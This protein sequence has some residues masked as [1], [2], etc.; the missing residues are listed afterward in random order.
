MKRWWLPVMA[1][2]LMAATACGGQAPDAA[3]DAVPSAALSSAP[4]VSS[5]S[6]TSKAPVSRP[7]D[8]SSS[9]VADEKPTDLREAFAALEAGRTAAGKL[10]SYRYD[11]SSSYAVLVEGSAV[12]L[13]SS[14]TEAAGD[15]ANFACCRT[16]VAK[17]LHNQQL[18][19]SVEASYADRAAGHTLTYR[20]YTDYQDAG[21]NDKSRREEDYEKL[22]LSGVLSDDLLFARSD[23]ASVSRSGEESF[24]FTLRA[25]A[26]AEIVRR[27][28][29]QIAPEEDAGSVSV[30]YF[31]VTARLTDGVLTQ[32][33][34][35]VIGKTGTENFQLNSRFT[36]SGLSAGETVSAPDWA[37]S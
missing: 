14:K 11:A 16:G 31:V 17:D 24:T 10:T 26:G 21:N 25:E 36:V 35:S 30:S 29:A 37:K 3:A 12:T 28:F 34:A 33:Q 22:P 6:A 13:D 19:A 23:V 5:A 7:A 32:Y 20:S 8:V 4:R 18:S 9:T 2:V 15:G 1:A 27:L